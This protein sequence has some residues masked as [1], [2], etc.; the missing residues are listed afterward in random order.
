MKQE[1]FYV[2]YSTF[3]IWF[4]SWTLIESLMT[5]YKISLDTKIKVVAVML[6]LALLNY[7]RIRETNESNE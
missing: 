2:V 6:V 3:F 7:T 5:Y 1:S 4:L